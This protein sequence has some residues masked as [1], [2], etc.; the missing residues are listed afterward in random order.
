MNSIHHVAKKVMRNKI[1]VPDLKR[2]DRGHVTIKSKAK[3]LSTK[4]THHS[5]GVN[6]RSDS[7]ST[8]PVDT[9]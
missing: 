6:P 2:G 8:F 4:R 3:I 7:V 1:K 9:H 5:L